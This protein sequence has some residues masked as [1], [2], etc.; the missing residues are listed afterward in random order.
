VL[1]LAF[2][3]FALGAPRAVLGQAT[4]TEGPAVVEQGSGVRITFAVSAPADVEVAV[5][6]AQGR[7]ARHLAAGV[8]GK[9]D[10]APPLKPSSL[11]QSLVWDRRDD[12]GRP[13]VSG[14]YKVRVRLGMQVAF[15]RVV[16]ADPYVIGAPRSLATDTRGNVYVMTQSYRAGDGKSGDPKYLG[17]AADWLDTGAPKDKRR[18][19]LWTRR[20]GAYTKETG[21]ALRNGHIL[22]WSLW[23]RSKK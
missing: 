5:L 4:L 13:A 8:V 6:D 3:V 1:G 21:K 19:V 18:L 23:K 20:S 14:T 9:K 22:L 2:A 16:G 15:G 12:L 10:A 17:D 7:V 11:A